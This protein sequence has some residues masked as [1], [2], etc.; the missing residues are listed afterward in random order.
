SGWRR[1]GSCPEI[2]RRSLS[3]TAGDDTSSVTAAATTF[4][5]G[6][7]VN[8]SG[9]D[10]FDGRGGADT[11]IGHFGLDTASYADRTAPV[12]ADA[13]GVADD[14]NSED[15]P[16]GSRANI[17]SDGERIVGGTEDDQL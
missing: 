1:R 7:V 8:E 17:P 3:G 2:R 6:E 9:N 11:Y 16:P 5:G 14:G 10:T 12:V 15:G 4:D 13:D